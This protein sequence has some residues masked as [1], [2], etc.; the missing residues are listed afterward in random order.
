MSDGKRLACGNGG[1]RVVLFQRSG[2]VL[3]ENAIVTDKRTAMPV[4]TIEFL[5]DERL[6]CTMSDSEYFEYEIHIY[7]VKYF[8][9]LELV[10]K[11]AG[12]GR[13][14]IT[15]PVRD[16]CVLI[17]SRGN[18]C[19]DLWDLHTQE[20]VQQYPR[21]TKDPKDCTGLL[22]QLHGADGVVGASDKDVLIWQRHVPDKP[23]HL[24]G[25]TGVVYGI[26]VNPTNSDE[27]VSYSLDG[28]FIVWRWSLKE[29]DKCMVM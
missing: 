14:A 22:L 28:S 4:D 29:K 26:L 15:S 20:L 9:S 1:G 24:K 7:S 2:R 21:H 27:F 16:A 23:Y 6:V 25:H 5:D 11:G 18:D 10:W 8:Y 3:A 19:M 12:T 17:G 13:Y